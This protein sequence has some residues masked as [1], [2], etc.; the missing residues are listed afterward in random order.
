MEPG[1]LH[2][3]LPAISAK[4]GLAEEKVRQA[5]SALEKART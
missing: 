1:A 3:E 5:L 4:S 2:L